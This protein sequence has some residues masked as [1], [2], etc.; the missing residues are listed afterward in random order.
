VIIRVDTDAAVVEVE[1]IDGTRRIPFSDPEAFALV[2]QAWLRTGWE[3][4]YSYR[5]TW[6]G[7][8][9]IQ[10]PEDV[11]RLQEAVMSTRPDV[12]VETGIAHGGSLVLYASL[13]ELLDHGHVVGVDVEIRPANRAA[14]EEHAL[15]PRI[16]LVEGSSIDPATFADVRAAV[17]A[18]ERVLVVLD[19]DHSREHVLQ[20]LRLYTTLVPVGSLLV[21]ADG[22][23]MRTVASAPEARPDWEWNNPLGAVDDFLAEHEG[24]VREDPAPLFDESSVQ[25]DVTYS[26]GGWLRRVR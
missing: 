11:M 9:I 13:C 10:L 18:A 15:F 14:L 5:F 7:R 21:V 12:I 25:R 17:A 6:L 3:A 22:S 16:T 19:S 2:S 26:A 24:F 20:E 1:E 23:I 4:K 8:P